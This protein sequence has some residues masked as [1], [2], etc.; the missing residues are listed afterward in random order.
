M[1]QLPGLGLNMPSHSCGANDQ[2]G[3]LV[4][5]PPAVT[6]WT[7]DHPIPLCDGPFGQFCAE[8]VNEFGGKSL[9]NLAPPP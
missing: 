2:R 4:A 6:L 3:E 7:P 5:A 8:S 9:A 1:N